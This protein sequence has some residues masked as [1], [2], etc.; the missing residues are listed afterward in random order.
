MDETTQTSEKQFKCPAAAKSWSIKILLMIIAIMLF[1]IPI[2]IVN[3]LSSERM[4]RQNIVY[5]EIS[6]AWGKKQL[7]SMFYTAEKEEYFVDAAPKVLYRGIYQVPVYTAK[8]N[9]K[10]TYL[11]P[12]NAVENRVV[13]YDIKAVEGCEVKIDG[14]AVDIK[15]KFNYFSFQ[16][17]SGKSR[18]DI[19][20]TLRGSGELRCG[21]NAATHEVNIKG[22]WDSPGFIGYT[23]PD[24]RTVTDKNFSAQW[25]GKAAGNGDSVGVEFCIPAGS[26]QQV[27][28]CIRYETF[29]LIIFFFTLVTSELVTKV[30]VHPLQY[31]VASGA[32]VLFYL[33]T[34]AFSEKFGFTAGYISSAAVVVGMTAMYARLFI[35]RLLP[36][37]VMGSVFAA[38]YFFNFILLRLEDWALFF[39]TVTLAIILGVMMA[40]T[41]KINRNTTCN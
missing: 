9:I 38:S 39:G 32:P 29:F 3:E 14:K 10:A 33:M 15:K 37:I 13:V 8:V 6:A 23:L 11:V 4:K 26:Y 41:G 25:I 28:R 35:G 17:P 19:T 5:E 2:F 31:I 24:T 34:L 7:V 18:C 27:E 16:L 1:Q 22:D 21:L 40:L 12:G 20:L 36:A 30:Y